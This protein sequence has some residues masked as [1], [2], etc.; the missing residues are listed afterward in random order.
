LRCRNPTWWLFLPPG[1]GYTCDGE[2]VSPSL[3]WSVILQGVGSLAL[4]V[5]DPGAPGGTFVHWV[6]YNRGPCPPQGSQHRYRFTLYALDRRIQNLPPGMK[7]SDLQAAMSR[8][9]NREL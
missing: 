4:I 6:I 5:E 8:A 9:A 1:G 7:A 3:A 2:D